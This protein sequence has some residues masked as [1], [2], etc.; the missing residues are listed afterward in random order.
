M[1]SPHRNRGLVLPAAA[2]LLALAIASCGSGENPANPAGPD[3]SADT[4][5][6]IS[7]AGRLFIWNAEHHA[8]VLK[9]AGLSRLARALSEKDVAALGNCFADNLSASIPS[10][11]DHREVRHEP[12]LFVE[13]L[14]SDRPGGTA[15]AVDGNRLA[16]W[17]AERADALPGG[18]LKVVPHV[19]RLSPD[20]PEKPD[21]AW[22]GTGKLEFFATAE[23]GART[24]SILLF[25]FGC[26]NLEETAL[27]S[28]RW[29]NRFQ[30]TS[31]AFGRTTQ[32]LM[33]EVAAESGFHTEAFWDN[34]KQPRE[35]RVTNTGGVYLTDFNRDGLH[36][37]FITDG[38]MSLFY[39]GFPDG[40]FR[41]ITAPVGIRGDRGGGIAAFVDLDGDGWEDLIHGITQHPDGYRI[42]HNLKGLTFEDVTERSNLPELLLGLSREEFARLEATKT[43]ENVQVK[44]TGFSIADYDL[45][46]RPD[47]Y[48]TRG[49]A[50]GF[51]DGSWIDGRADARANNQ[52]LRNKGDWQFEDVTHGSPLDGERRS[53]TNAVWL[54]ADDDF[55]PDLYVID[56][57]GDGI[58]LLN[59]E[60]GF[61]GRSL[62]D[63]PTDFGSMGMTAGDIDNDGHTEIYVAEMYSK[64]G[65]R[66]MA[67]LPPGAYPPEVDR[68]LK[69]LVDGSQLYRGLGGGRFEGVGKEFAVQGVGWAWGACFTDLDND[70]WLDLYA[71]AGFISQERGK[72]DG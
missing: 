35:R 1:A 46:G 16:E 48:V 11:A 12:D 59:K 25:E 32:P 28:T 7:E 36:D 24:E 53:T 58:L 29:L 62:N 22:S 47:L 72:P 56:E 23:S 49:A 60:A 38:N 41:E 68:K 39:I 3:P 66:V 18:A 44:P 57:F 30:V 4:R 65:E 71:T 5:P 51:K 64:A 15:L 26:P 37:V 69:R 31:F 50:G 8:N 54:Y 14:R 67:N 20:D 61:E 43:L 13:R 55:R 45:D 52:L 17:L 34:W 63:Q 2:S 42:Y 6:L 10:D 70:G 9:S 33:R 21:G 19:I 27:A 40:K